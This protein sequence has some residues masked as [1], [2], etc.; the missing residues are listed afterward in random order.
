MSVLGHNRQTKIYIHNLINEG[1]V[2]DR[3][4]DAGCGTG[5][6]G[7]TLAEM[8]PNAHVL[9]TDINQ[10]LLA[11]LNAS[12]VTSG[13]FSVGVSDLSNPNRVVLFNGQGLNLESESYDI[14]N[15]SANIAYSSDQ[16]KTIRILYDLLKPGGVI[17]DLEM[18]HGILGRFI[19][20]L[21]SYPMVSPET[22]E[23]SLDGSGAK[24]S[25]TKIFFKYFPLNLTRECILIEK[26]SVTLNNFT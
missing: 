8:F 6:A 23:Q 16:E 20:W 1:R 26:P 12:L 7:V 3:I 9:F 21:Y 17:I 15:A 4:L 10:N 2:A 19:S 13:L 18:H 14:I 5:A 24:I 25:R 11:K 22:I